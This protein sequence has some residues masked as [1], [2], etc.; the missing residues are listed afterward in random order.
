[1]PP[2]VPAH[3][4][5][6]DLAHFALVA[7]EFPKL[8]EGRPYSTA[9]L[10]RERHG[11]VGEIRAIGEVV[12]DHLPLLARCGFDAFQ[13]KPG[14]DAGDA[15]AAFGEITVALQPSVRSFHTPSRRA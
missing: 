6:A 4:I 1:V 3:E 9:R 11:F 13:L 8:G 7:L 14:H 15:L 10:L 5:A 12:R 2:E